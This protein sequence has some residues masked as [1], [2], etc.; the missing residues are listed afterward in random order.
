MDDGVLTTSLIYKS[1]QI[2][3]YMWLKNVFSDII[4]KVLQNLFAN[5]MNFSEVFLSNDF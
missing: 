4:L 1:V 5:L 2:R 3:N